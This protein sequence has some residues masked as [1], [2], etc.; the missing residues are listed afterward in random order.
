MSV[1]TFQVKLALIKIMIKPAKSH[2]VVQHRCNSMKLLEF[3]WGMSY[4]NLRVENLYISTANFV[5]VRILG[6]AVLTNFYILITL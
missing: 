6:G 1:S 2:Y 5:G 4:I 3:S